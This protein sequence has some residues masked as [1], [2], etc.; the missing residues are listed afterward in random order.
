MVFMEDNPPH[1]VVGGQCQHRPL[2]RALWGHGRGRSDE[3]T[4]FALDCGDIS[5]DISGVRLVDEGHRELLGGNL[6]IGI[7]LIAEEVDVGRDV[8]AQRVETGLSIQFDLGTLDVHDLAR[9][10]QK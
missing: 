1:Q 7:A 5:D 3:E 9:I 8:G 2:Q 6:E 4:H 10:I